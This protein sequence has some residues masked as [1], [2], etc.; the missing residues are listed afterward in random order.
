MPDI[1]KPY[2]GW[3][4]SFF[5][6][7]THVPFVMRWPNRLNAGTRYPHAISHLDIMPTALGA[8]SLIPQARLIDGVNLLP[9]LGG[10][11][12]GAPHDTLIW[13]EGHYQAVLSDGW[14]MQRSASPEK[15]RLFNLAQDPFEKN[16]LSAARGDKLAELGQLLDAHNDQQA[17]PM[18]PSNVE[19]PI[20]VDKSL[21]D[22][23]TL[24]DEFI[25]WPN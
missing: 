2:R 10:Q 6:G 25:Y 5:E 22:Q 7:G 9:Y 24:D 17:K 13:R 18:W 19:I 15:I 12:T 4:L 23:P 20:W 11:K 3:K 1:N 8:A 14:K 16:D 21:S